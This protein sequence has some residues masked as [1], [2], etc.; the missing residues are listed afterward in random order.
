MAAATIVATASGSN[1][2][3][4]FLP[5]AVGDTACTLSPGL[6]PN[7]D[8]VQQPDNQPTKKKGADPHLIQM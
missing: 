3:S 7:M 1:H 2:N 6:P 4:A 5:E 8:Q